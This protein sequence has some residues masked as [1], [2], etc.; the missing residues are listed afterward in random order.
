LVKPARRLSKAEWD[1]VT[2]DYLGGMSTN[3]IGRKYGMYPQTIY[4]R[5]KASG[6]P[7]RGRTGATISGE[8]LEEA[9]RLRRRGWTFAQIG[10]HF[11]VS[12]AAATNALKRAGHG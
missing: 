4:N 10:A 9:V 11:G 5:L 6:V 2:A 8:K 1:Q 3:A 12:R 7:I